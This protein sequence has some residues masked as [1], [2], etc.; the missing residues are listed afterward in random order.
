MIVRSRQALLAKRAK[1]T[2]SQS[3]HQPPEYNKG[4]C[5]MQYRIRVRPRRTPIKTIGLGCAIARSLRHSMRRGCV[6]PSSRRLRWEIFVGR[7]RPCAY[8][9]GKGKKDRT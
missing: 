3:S 4:E 6:V 9:A 1:A 7:V 5:G 2:N 8:A